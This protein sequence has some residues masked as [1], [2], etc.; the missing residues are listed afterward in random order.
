MALHEVLGHAVPPP[1]AVPGQVA[2]LPSYSGRPPP[3]ARGTAHALRS[4]VAQSHGRNALAGLVSG[5]KGG[6]SCCLP[7]WGWETGGSEPLPQDPQEAGDRLPCQDPSPSS[8]FMQPHPLWG[9][10]WC[11][12]P[13]QTCPRSAAPAP[14]RW[15]APPPLPGTIPDQMAMLVVPQMRSV[16]TQA[17][18]PCPDSAP[19]S[20]KGCVVV[21][22]RQL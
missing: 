5:L 7:G 8:G 15:A 16:A 10:Q 19:T 1:Y 17:R 9:T 21:F 18:V 3:G 13:L 6:T 12:D 2:E 20:P 14:A 11:G 4:S 22:T